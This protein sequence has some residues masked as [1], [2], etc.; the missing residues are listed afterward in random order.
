[1]R[2]APL[3]LATPSIRCFAVTRYPPEVTTGRDLLENLMFYF[4]CCSV[5]LDADRLSVVAGTL[6]SGGVCPV[7]GERV[8][9]RE[10]VSDRGLPLLP[11]LYAHHINNENPKTVLCR[12][13]TVC[14]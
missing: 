10:T 1:M 8:F 3:A 12:S 6:A 4:K 13:E 2:S 7:T 5:Q 9:E 11:S 14:L